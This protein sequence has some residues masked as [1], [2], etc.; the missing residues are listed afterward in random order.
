[1]KGG[2]RDAAGTIL[3]ASALLLVMLG[4]AALAALMWPI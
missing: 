2:F 4:V 1:V 3:V